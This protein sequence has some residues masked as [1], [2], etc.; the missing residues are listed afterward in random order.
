M[1]CN[2]LK[3]LINETITYS[4]L[5]EHYILYYLNSLKC[6]EEISVFFFNCGK[7]KRTNSSLHLF[8]FPTDPERAR[9]WLNNSGK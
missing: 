4:T 3:P 7:S 5:Y 8:K 6:K 2:F 1:Y 9:L